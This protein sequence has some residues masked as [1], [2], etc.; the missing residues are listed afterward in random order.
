M[1]ILLSGIMLCLAFHNLELGFRLNYREA[2]YG[3]RFDTGLKRGICNGV[4]MSYEARI[5]NNRRVAMQ[6][7]HDIIDTHPEKG[8][9]QIITSATPFLA[10]VY[11]TP[12]YRDEDMRRLQR[13]ELNNGGTKIK[14]QIAKFGETR[15]RNIRR[16]KFK[17]VTSLT[18]CLTEAT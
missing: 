10:V 11:E 14:P 17:A 1:M 7:L 4:K 5:P 3:I 16:F 2:A 8:C 13:L 9:Y 18:F 6:K 12:A 15:N